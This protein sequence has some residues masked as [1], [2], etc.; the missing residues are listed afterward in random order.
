MVGNFGEMKEINECRRIERIAAPLWR[1]IYL[2]RFP[3]ARV[4]DKYTD[5]GWQR[6]GKGDRI[7]EMV[8]SR[9]YIDEKTMGIDSYTNAYLKGR[10]WP[11]EIKGNT[12][13]ASLGS[14]IF[15]TKANIWALG[16][17]NQSLN[18]PIMLL[19][20][21][22][23]VNLILYALANHE[24]PSVFATTRTSEGSYKTECK[25]VPYHYIEDCLYGQEPTSEKND[26][27]LLS[28]KPKTAQK[29]LFEYLWLIP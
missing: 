20:W 28:I 22:V 15:A 16:F 12:S 25:E 17:V 21:L 5:S 2:E 14:S 27:V 29:G 23:D 6:S 9:L 13:R 1:S 10:G 3:G 7:I 19:H 24:F 8:S 11:I 26:D 18:P 4:I